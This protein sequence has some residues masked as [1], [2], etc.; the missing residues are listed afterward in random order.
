[1]SSEA[2]AEIDRA[3]GIT[4]K[5]PW[6]IKALTVLPEYRLA[7]TFQDGTA[8]ICDMSALKTATNL[9]IYAPLADPNVFS[10]ARLELG[11]VTWPNGAD[12]DPQWMHE[13]IERSESWSVPF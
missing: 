11:T 12:L 9:G 10:Q 5:A 6:R 1:M 13:E 3:A 7:V 4:P 2:T 8:G